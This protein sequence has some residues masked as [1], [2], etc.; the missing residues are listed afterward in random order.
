MLIPFLKLD[1]YLPGSVKKK[2]TRHP[3]TRV[4]VKLSGILSSS[5]A[6]NSSVDFALIDLTFMIITAW[7]LKMCHK[8]G[9][10]GVIISKLAKKNSRQQ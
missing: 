10:Q 8:I 3:L 5:T 4:V 6:F 1:F 2:L 9:Y 7:A